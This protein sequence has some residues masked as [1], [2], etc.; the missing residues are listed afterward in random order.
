MIL[1][2]SQQANDI[3]AVLQAIGLPA[4]ILFVSTLYYNVQKSK[5]ELETQGK[6]IEKLEQ[7]T[8]TFKKDFTDIFHGIE[9][10]LIEIK[11]KLESLQEKKDQLKP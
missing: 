9:K 7:E 4:I 1:Q 11:Y 8:S 5:T 10:S 2:I 6:K 3:L